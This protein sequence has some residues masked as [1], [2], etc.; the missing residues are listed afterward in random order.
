MNDDALAVPR[1]LSVGH[2]Q[3]ELPRFLELLRSA[4]VTAVA[5]VRSSPFS[6]RLPQFNRPVL[7]E[8]LQEAGKEPTGHYGVQFRL[9]DC[10]FREPGAYVVRLFLDGKIVH[11][12]PIMVR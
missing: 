6:Q 4:G 5:D 7:Q 2:S 9:L 3:H 12:Q 8:A 10:A 11:E 1:F